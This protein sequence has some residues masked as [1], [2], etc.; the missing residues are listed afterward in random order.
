MVTDIQ[1]VEQTFLLQFT[2]GFFMLQFLKHC[3]SWVLERKESGETIGSFTVNRL[4]LIYLFVLPTFL[5]T[6]VGIAVLSIEHSNVC[7]VL[8]RTSSHGIGVGVV[9]TSKC[10]FPRWQTDKKNQTNPNKNK[11]TKRTKTWS[12]G[13]FPLSDFLPLLSTSSK[14]SPPTFTDEGWHS[15]QHTF[16]LQ[17]R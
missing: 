4:E 2:V 15:M 17:L 9:V 11:Q 14:E 13:A 1:L 8:E 5:V 10:R 3:N 6:A 16:R 7:C 12:P